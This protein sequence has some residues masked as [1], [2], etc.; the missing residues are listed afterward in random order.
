MLKKM[1]KKHRRPG[2][3]TDKEAGHIHIVSIP[4]Q[5]QNNYWWNET[6]SDILEVFGLPGE[7]Y[8]SHPGQDKMDFYFKSERD[9][10]ICRILVSE[11]I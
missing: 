2:I 3:V 7:R 11:K 9:A 10:D 4:W 1:I 6:C 5:G 8:T